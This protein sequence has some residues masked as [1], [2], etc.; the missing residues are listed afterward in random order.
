[1]IIPYRRFG[2]TCR[3]LLQ[4]STSP[5]RVQI[6]FAS[7]R[8]PEMTQ[9]QAFVF[10]FCPT[11]NV[12]F[13][14]IRNF[15]IF[16]FLHRTVVCGI[17]FYKTSECIFYDAYCRKVLLANTLPNWKHLSDTHTQICRVSSVP[18]LSGNLTLGCMIN[19]W[20]VLVGRRVRQRPFGGPACWWEDTVI[21]EL[22]PASRVL[23][24]E[25]GSF[26]SW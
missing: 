24:C 12:Y 17:Y 20:Q 2:T 7:R 23:V 9:K 22:C 18:T 4:G 13:E 26:G 10:Y 14:S 11:P 16:L 15:C 5:N 25:V 8:K 3:S 19:A 21:A 1:M 6:S